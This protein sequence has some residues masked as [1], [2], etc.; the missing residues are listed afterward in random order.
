MR[1]GIYTHVLSDDPVDLTNAVRFHS[2]DEIVP[3]K[4]VN[5]QRLLLGFYWPKYKTADLSPAVLLIHG[6]GWQSKKV[7]DDQPAWAG[8]YLGFLARHLANLGYVCVSVD[9]RLAKDHA[10]PDGFQLIDLFDDCL[11]AADYIISN[12]HRYGIDRNRVI[13]LGESAGG[14]L[15]GALATFPSAQHLSLR[16]AILVNPIMDFVNDSFWQA[17]VPKKSVHPVLKD[18]SFPQRCV[19]LSPL[20]KICSRTCPIVLLHGMDDSVVSPEHSIRTYES[21]KDAG[22]PCQL[23]LFEKTNHA[24]LLT[25]FTDNQR[26]CRLG[27]KV[28]TEAL[29]SM[30]D[31]QAQTM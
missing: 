20:W 4:E 29:Y 17:Y 2:A 31:D 21:M 1:S 12:S 11:D 30:L 25:E 5:G 16:G 26:A 23:H 18:L 9:Y 8:D 3:Y 10:Q 14:Q 24:F 22:R 13:V 19:Y 27:V 6:G 28:I 7:F 15:A